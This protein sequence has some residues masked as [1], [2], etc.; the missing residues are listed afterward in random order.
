MPDASLHARLTLVVL[1]ASAVSLAEAQTGN[2]P[3]A[4]SASSL[5][6]LSLDELGSIEVTTTNKVPETVWQTDAAI[7]VITQEDIRRSGAAT[8]P[9]ALRL[10]PGVI[11]NQSDS[12][13][14]AVGIRGFADIFSKSVLVLIDGRSVYTPLV[15][16]VHWAIQE[17]LLADVERIEVIRGPGGSVWG[18]NAMNGIINVITKRAADTPGVRVTAAGG[19]VEQ[20]RVSARFGGGNNRNLDYRVYGRWVSRGD[21][22]HPDKA[23]FDDWHATQAGFRTDWEP[24][25]K[26]TVTVSGDIYRTRVG[27]R[28]LLGSF[29]PVAQSNVEGRIDLTG[30]NVIA[31]WQRAIGGGQTRLQAYYDRTNRDG[32]TFA[33]VRN[34]FDLDFNARLPRWRRH[35]LSFGGGARFSPS[36]TTQVS[37]TLKFLPADR[38]HTLYSGF[39]HDDIQVRPRVM[40]SAGAKI[41]HN[42]YTGAEVLPSARVLWTPGRQ[43]SLWAG[44][45]RSVRTP[46]RFDRDLDFSLLVDPAAPIYFALIGSDEF[47]TETMIGLEA[48]YRKLVTKDLYFDAALFSN[49]YDRLSGIGAALPPTFETSPI[50]YLR[51]AVPFANTIEA[52]TRGFELTPD[53]KPL[54]AWQLKGSYAYL[55]VSAQGRPGFTD[56]TLGDNYEASGPRHQ[57]KVQSRFDVRR[58]QLDQMYRYSS[59]LGAGVEPYHTL[60]ARIAGRLSTHMELALVGQNLLQAHHVEFNP[61]NLPAPVEIRRSVYVQLVATR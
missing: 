33:E 47:D 12:S 54:P 22:Y 24:T 51:V 8:L 4:R 38:S 7:H 52:R 45:T 14:W 57:V 26:D 10:A 53:W 42:S 58:I 2:S 37:Q 18:A 39:V 35:V 60:D 28:S 46:S 61:D 43:Q 6:A 15:G 50:P 30:A 44:V 9:D 49:S 25:L 17:L 36:S 1:L 29:T 55:W 41:E 5:K 16:G 21:Q 3:P 31:R 48:G 59:R 19:N 20:G 13:R 23:N 56:P 40:L 34:T 27:E 11:V 32:F